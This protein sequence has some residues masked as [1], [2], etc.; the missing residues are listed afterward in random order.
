MDEPRAPTPPLPRL[1]LALLELGHAG[2]LGW[3]AAVLPW[4]SFTL[5]AALT[6]ALAATHAVTG[7]LAIARHRWLAI[8]WRAESIASLAYLLYLTHGLFTSGLYVAR[9]YG[10]LGQGIAAIAAAVWAVAALFTVPVACWGIAATGG[11]PR[12]PWLGVGLGVA[13]AFGASAWRWDRLAAAEPAREAP[14]DDTRAAL[15][16]IVA[17]WSALPSAPAKASLRAEAPATCPG[18]AGAQRA[19]IVVTYLAREAAR[20]RSLCEQGESL[21]EAA[22]ALGAKIAADG[23][24]GPM[25][26]DVVT[27]AQRI[28]D[29][30]PLLGSLAL[31]PALDGVC[32]G[33]KCLMP[34][35][36]AAL[37]HF[38]RNSP[39]PAFGLRFGVEAGA[40]RA[41][42]GGAAAGGF[43]G[44]SR[45]ETRSFVVDDR[46]ALRPLFR[47]REERELTADTLERAT[48]A[49]LEFILASQ[50]RDGRFR[51][52]VDPFTGKA[53]N[54]D[55]SV[56]RQAGTTLVVCELGSG[57]RAVRA[58]E[59][60]L[61]MLARLEQA[62]GELGVI[63]YPR[64]AK[65][66]SKLGTTALSLIAFLGCRDLVGSGNDALIHRL[67]RYLLAMQRPDGGFHPRWDLAK[68]A[69]L[70]GADP[71]YAGGQ[72]ILALVLWEA[73]PAASLPGSPSREARRAAID[74]AMAHFAGPYWD[75]FMKDFFYMEENWHCLAARAALAGH[76]NDAYERF[77]LDYVTW[78]T[79]LSLDDRSR[80]S[81]EFVGGYGLGNVLPPQ[82]TVTAGFGEAL[83]AAIAVK[84]ARGLDAA[85]EKAAM[86]RTLRFLVRQQWTEVSCFACAREIEVVGG[87]SENV[88]SPQIRI[89]YV[90]HALAALGHG[91]RAIGLL[92]R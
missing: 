84:E 9:L 52:L 14:G 35:Q 30:N 24:R 59:S 17:A 78:K 41:A 27:A 26:I 55:F 38:N 43:A 48:G 2:V 80:V 66:P 90:Q 19:A 3:A 10:S 89:D 31:R 63:T 15:A 64:G 13:L 16:P 67:G 4:R 54:A 7:A 74:R 5:F 57:P 22:S 87:F 81:D 45:I 32:L 77:C 49:A 76:R 11:L 21:G 91:G 47:L 92:R 62:S 75:S 37:D 6:G 29:L 50:D 60:S 23:L 46:G 65:E 85:R 72:S 8:V 88:G 25:K 71:L 56:A 73:L 58:A 33:A 42:L 28:P 61:A 44:L 20:A 51:Y 79:R 83:A 40:L 69:P 1:S 39:A 36:L 53:S 70:P 12:R 34:W 18:D 82:S 68:K 86:A